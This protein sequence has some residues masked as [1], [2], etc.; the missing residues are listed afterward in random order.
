MI[1]FDDCIPQGVGAEGPAVSCK[2]ATGHPQ[3]LLPSRA[4]VAR[5]GCR[6]SPL[7]RLSP[8]ART[9]LARGGNGG[10]A[11]VPASLARVRIEQR[12]AAR[13][14]GQPVGAPRVRAARAARRGRAAR[15]HRERDGGTVRDRRRVCGGAGR[16]RGHCDAQL[17]ARRGG[18]LLRV[19]RRWGARARG[20]RQS[21]R[22]RSSAGCPAPRRPR[23]LPRA[24]AAPRRGW[25]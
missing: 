6:L 15:G 23:T 2:D 21:A 22:A 25:T 5:G 17:G 8:G 7:T 16:G 19:L 18:L 13:G 12:H 14:M 10:L 4:A 11:L 1:G 9:A 24:P 3:V 20:A